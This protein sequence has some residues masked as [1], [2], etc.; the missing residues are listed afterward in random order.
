VASTTVQSVRDSPSIACRVR[1]ACQD[2]LA[3]THPTSFDERA[4]MDGLDKTRTLWLYRLDRLSDYG[5]SILHPFV[6]NND[7]LDG[8]LVL[9]CVCITWKSSLS[10]LPGDFYKQWLLYAEQTTRVIRY[11]VPHM[12]LFT[13]LIHESSPL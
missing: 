8:L 13:S 11:T 12:F 10:I 5:L 9:Q 7:I 4:S 3:L 6:T 2:F 1:H